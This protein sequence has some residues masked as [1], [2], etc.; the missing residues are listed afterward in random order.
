MEPSTEVVRPESRALVNPATG[1]LT[2]LDDAAACLRAL[3]EVRELEDQLKFAKRVL[4]DAIAD[5]AA[6]QGTK[7]LRFPGITAT[8]SNR[9]EI[10][11]DL[12]VLERL[13]EAGL[14]GERYADLI[15][16]EVTYKVSVREADRIAGANPAYNEIILKA[17]TDFEGSPYVGSI[18]RGGDAL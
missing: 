6:R 7:T 1:E 5:E 17:R 12:E 8:V 18:V 11:W 13:L 9:K 14:P 15:K 2:S 16:T 4:S 3:A 10:Q